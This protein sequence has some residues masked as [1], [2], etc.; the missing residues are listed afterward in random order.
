MTG[1]YQLS[2]DPVDKFTLLNLIAITYSKKIK[3]IE[4]TEL[5][6]DR[7]LNSDRLR[8]A[9]NLQ[10]PS[11]QVLISEMHEDYQKRYIK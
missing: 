10:I 7:S 9:L 2:A 8:S 4:S 6:I 3:I 11:W 5:Q 1:L